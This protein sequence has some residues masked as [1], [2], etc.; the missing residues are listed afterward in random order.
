M[1]WNVVADTKIG[2]TVWAYTDDKGQRITQ[3]TIGPN[4]VHLTD[5]QRTSLAEYLSE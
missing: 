5:E 4:Y 3:L 1:T 2:I